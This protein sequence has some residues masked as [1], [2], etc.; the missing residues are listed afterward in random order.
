MLQSLRLQAAR[1]GTG[2]D[3]GRARAGHS[4]QP[5]AKTGGFQGH[6][7]LRK[8]Q[9]DS[10]GHSERWNELSS[11]AVGSRP[12]TRSGCRA[13]CRARPS[14]G[15]QWPG[16]VSGIPA[17]GPQGQRPWVIRLGFPCSH[18]DW[19]A[20]EWWAKNCAQ[21]G[22]SHRA[23]GHSGG[24]TVRLW[25]SHLGTGPREEGT[26][27]DWEKEPLPPSHAEQ[28]WFYS[29]DLRGLMTSWTEELNSWA[30]T[31][32]GKPGFG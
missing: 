17:I 30:L 21:W 31:F 22:T 4:G 6:Q 28:L 11:W 26:G 16:C 10:W 19:R 8:S 15:A 20:T 27:G 1:P 13:G 12:R 14:R 7:N 3:T 23:S 5:G 25:P 29:E 9:F 2:S 18:P 32:P 24:T